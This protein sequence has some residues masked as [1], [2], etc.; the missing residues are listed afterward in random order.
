MWV[1]LILFG[2]LLLAGFGGL[3]GRGVY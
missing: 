1:V 3:T 2:L